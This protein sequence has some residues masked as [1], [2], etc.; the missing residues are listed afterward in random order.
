MTTKSQVGLGSDPVRNFIPHP[1]GRNY[2]ALLVAPH[3]HSTGYPRT[4]QMI[5]DPDSTPEE[6]KQTLWFEYRLRHPNSSDREI[7]DFET[8]IMT[9]L[10]V[11][12]PQLQGL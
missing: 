2:A 1:N 6:I 12:V 7:R 11:S 5:L 10:R 8:M 9:R 3:P 4:R